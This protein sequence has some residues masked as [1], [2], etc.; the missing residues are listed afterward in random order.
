MNARKL[1]EPVCLDI[2][3]KWRGDE[4]TGR[5]QMDEILREVVIITDSEDEGGDSSDDETTDEEEG[6]ISDSNPISPAA[7]APPTGVFSTQPP[8]RIN[9]PSRSQ[10]NAGQDSAHAISSRTRSRMQP[11]TRL[12]NAKQRGFSR[13][14]AAWDQA[15]DRQ[16]GPPSQ[17]ISSQPL[18]S[19]TKN[20]SSN[21]PRSVAPFSPHPFQPQHRPSGSQTFDRQP[22]Y[23]S[24]NQQSYEA[25][26]AIQPVSWN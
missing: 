7:S 17:P 10:N 20:M 16:Q 6:E 19:P 25:N 8:P 1:V 3:V 11:K 13:Y 9:N 2:L 21:N 15:L 24:M 5:D 23:S 4:E 14:Q 26:S 22:D 12:E 18:S